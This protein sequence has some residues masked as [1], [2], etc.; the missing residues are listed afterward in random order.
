MN[1]RLVKADFDGSPMQFNPDGWFNATLAAERFGKSPYEWQRLPETV[2]YMQALEIR[3][4]K[5]P[6]VKTSRAR[7][8]R[9]GG[10][11]LHPKLA[12]RFAQ[13]LDV[14]FAIWCDEQVDALIRGTGDGWE[15]V[16]AGAA[17]QHSALCDMVRLTRQAIGKTTQPHHYA[18]EARLINLALTGS[19]SP[20]NRNSLSKPELRLLELIERQD[21]VLMGMGQP[22]EQRKTGLLAF[23][24][25]ERQRLPALRPPMKNA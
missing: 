17:H 13:W 8:D 18:N 11:W 2:R 19:A 20:V 24:A 22:Y 14:D 6:Y 3:Y 16:R 23:A 1:A 10:T 5:I 7:A 12:V 25:A 9:G 21:M 15:A 4:G